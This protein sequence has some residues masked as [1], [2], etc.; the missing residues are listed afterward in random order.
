MS[1]PRSGCNTWL[2][3][4]IWL[5]STLP[6]S[7]DD[8]MAADDLR[9]LHASSYEAGEDGN[10]Y[11]F[12]NEGET[13]ER[14]FGQDED[15]DA[16]VTDYFPE[17]PVAFEH[18]YTFLSLFDSDENSIYRK[19]NLYYLFLSRREWQVAAWLLRSGLSMGKIDSFLALE[20]IQDLQWLKK[21][22]ECLCIF[23]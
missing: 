17:P 4:L 21:V 19:T 11:D 6:A 8:P 14:G 1:Q 7:E 10:I 15:R 3:D 12:G 2:E 20:M 23:K 13:L 22:S 5:D 18:G 9:E 16:E